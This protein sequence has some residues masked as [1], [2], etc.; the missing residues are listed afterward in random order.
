MNAFYHP[1]VRYFLNKISNIVDLPGPTE[2]ICQGGYHYIHW[3]HKIHYLQIKLKDVE[4]QES[5]FQTNFRFHFTFIP[6]HLLVFND[7]YN[8]ISSGISF[9]ELIPHL[10]VMA[11]AYLMDS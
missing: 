3:K 9:T 4:G 5:N 8:P 11:M 6:G 1:V 10:K 2:I 7:E